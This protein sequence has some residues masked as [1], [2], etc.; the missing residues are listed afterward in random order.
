LILRLAQAVA[1]TRPLKPYPGWRFGVGEGAGGNVNLRLAIWV[2]CNRRKLE[3]PITMEWYH[4]TQTYVYL[5][6]DISRCLFVGGCIEPNEFA[7]L[8][9][10]IEPG[11][12]FIDVGANE[13]LYTLFAAKRADTTIALEPS[14]REF[15]RLRANI[16][17]NRL[18]NVKAR[19]IALSDHN[20]EA[21]LRVSGYEH[22]G[23]NTLGSF[24][25]AGVE[26]S[27]TEKVKVRRLDDLVIEEGLRSVDVIK[28]DVEGAEYSALRGARRTLVEFRPLLLIEIFDTALRH[29]GSSAAD[30][31]EFLKS[32]GYRIYA[33]DQVSGRPAQAERHTESSSNIVAA[34][35]SRSWRGVND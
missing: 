27:H 4:G 24:S 13:G 34:H 21:A 11:M 1:R 9:G 28:L 17:L 25:Y 7:F 3:K 23:Q 31:L 10:V 8:D 15:E 33:F 2:Y 12:V 26:L 14:A 35:P 19:R 32:L 5:G 16:E 29:Q 20:G 30:V 22:E 6:N 18:T